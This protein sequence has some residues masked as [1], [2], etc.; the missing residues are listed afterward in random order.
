MLKQIGMQTQHFTVL[1]QQIQL[2]KLFH[3][4]TTDLQLRIQVELND[5]PMLEEE[6]LEEDNVPEEAN[7]EQDFLDTDEYAYD[8]IPDYKLEHNNYL[9][10]DHPQRPFA[11]PESFRATLKQQIAVHLTTP[12]ENAI[13][14]FLIDSLDEEGLLDLDLASIADDVSFQN[15]VIVETSEVE[16]V[17]HILQSMEPHGLGCRSMVEFLLFQLRRMPTET[18]VTNSIQLLS[19]HFHDLSHRQMEKIA[20]RLHIT[21]QALREAIQFIATLPRKP[22]A[23]SQS[24]TPAPRI[25]PDFIITQEGGN[26]NVSL[27]RQR[28]SVVFVNQS[29]TT[30]L[31]KQEKADKATLLYLKSKLNSAQWF[32]EAIK[33]RETTM[34]SI[35]NEM[36]M[37]QSD[38]FQEGDVRLLKPMVLKNIAEKIG[39]DI[40][41]VSRITCNKYADTP[42]GTIALKS[43]FSEGVANEQGERISNRVIQLAIREVVDVEDSNAP[44][45][46]QQL[47]TILSQRGYSIARRTVSKYREHLRI[48]TA[49][50][51]MA[52]QQYSQDT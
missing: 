33:Q 44:Y 9:A 11:E 14:A 32:V 50:H 42:F 37:F 52:A 22:L 18:V 23:E 46:D 48:P 16:K 36:V 40:S 2:L 38:Y 19:A 49:Q 28:S 1:P 26:L 20:T 47:V 27:F 21:E 15:Q 10:E 8:D 41:T 29:L 7:T 12:Q 35:M 4:T 3:L 24:S 31:E 34:L 17:L 51:R 30:M 25:I 39:M 5:N 6:V 45:T 13:A 43:L